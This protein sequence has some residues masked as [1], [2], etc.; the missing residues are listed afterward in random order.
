MVLFSA[1]KGLSFLDKISVSISCVNLCF[2]RCCY[3]N[4]LCNPRSV[5]FWYSEILVLYLSKFGLVSALVFLL[6][7]KYFEPITFFFWTVLL[8]LTLIIYSVFWL[9]FDLQGNIINWKRT[10]LRWKSKNHYFRRNIIDMEHDWW[11]WDSLG[12]KEKYLSDTFT[13]K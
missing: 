3:N 2:K 5:T 12:L 10:S 11:H 4:G 1:C 6:H 9:W 13:F 7:K 8:P